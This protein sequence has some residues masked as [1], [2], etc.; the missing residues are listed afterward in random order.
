M[1]KPIDPQ[2]KLGEV[3]IIEITFDPRD[4][5]EIPQLLKGLQYIYCEPQLR[6]EIFAIM[7]AEIGSDKSLQTGRPGMELWKIL[8]LGTLRLNCNWDYDKLKNMAD[9]HI[10]IRQMLGVGMVDMD[11]KFPLSTL[12]DNVALLTPEILEKINTL[13]VKTGHQLIKKKGADVVLQVRCDSFVVETDVEYPTDTQLL[14]DAV[15]KQVEICANSGLPGWRQWEHLLKKL[16]KALRKAQKARTSRSKDPAKREKGKQRVRA[17]YKDFLALV[18]SLL[19]RVEATTAAL[20]EGG[21]IVQITAI[22]YFRQHADH[23]I[24]QIQRRVFNGET[25]PHD[26]KTFSIFEPHTRWIQKGKAGVPFELGLPVCVVEDQY[27]FILHHHV[28]ASE[29]DVDVAV[30]IIEKVKELFPNLGGCSFDKGFHSLENQ[31]DLA[32]ILDNVILPR[33]GKLTEAAREE[34]RKEEFRKGRK[35]H[36]QVESA[37]SALENHGLDRCLD[38][39]LFGFRRYVAMAVLARNVQQLGKILLQSDAKQDRRRAA[40]R[41]AA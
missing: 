12:R 13:V 26:E 27:R 15:R 38:H 18:N 8:V 16:R 7:E 10:N 3:N 14:F 31:A 11:T 21:N 9:N 34:E 20:I 36:S 39:G 33:K 5:D 32:G 25:I 37:I 28:M 23:Q 6:E 40:K 35:R 41:L 22:K 2:F 29:Y 17:A 30:P 24:D 19:L 4:R 1:R